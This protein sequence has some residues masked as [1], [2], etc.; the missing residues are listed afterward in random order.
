MAAEVFIG[1]DV[2]RD[3]LE[4]AARPAGRHWQVANDAAGIA[5]LVPQLRVLTPTL[6]VLEATGGVELPLLA[7]LGSAQLPVV[8]VNRAKCGISPRRPASWPRPTPSTP[9][10]WPTS[11]KRC[12]RPCGRCRMRRARRWQPW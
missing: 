12:A 4:V 3:S 1:I 2:A 8:A 7:A 10:C 5:A 11:P 6:I 9:R